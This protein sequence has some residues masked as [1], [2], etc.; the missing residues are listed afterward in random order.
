[1]SKYVYAIVPETIDLVD[2]VGYDESDLDGMSAE[3]VR[4]LAR[5]ELSEPDIRRL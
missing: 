3:V 1:M 4:E 5:V 2:D